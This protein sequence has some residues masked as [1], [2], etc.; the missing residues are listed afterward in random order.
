M[1][2]YRI[3]IRLEEDIPLDDVRSIPAIERYAEALCNEVDWN[4]IIDGSDRAFRIDG[5]GA[6]HR[7]YARRLA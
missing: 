4:A 1:T 3:D 2:F 5:R 7:A 6:T